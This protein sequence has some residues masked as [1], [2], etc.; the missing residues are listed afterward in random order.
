M[1]EAWQADPWSDADLSDADL[2]EEQEDFSESVV[3]RKPRQ[4]VPSTLHLSEQVKLH[5]E[6]NAE[7]RIRDSGTERQW[8][9]AMERLEALVTPVMV[10]PATLKERLS[11][12]S[13]PEDSFYWRAHTLAESWETH[14]QATHPLLPAVSPPPITAEENVAREA[15]WMLQGLDQGAFAAKI[16]TSITRLRHLTPGGLRQYLAEMC[17]LGQMVAT[18]DEFTQSCSAAGAHLTAENLISYETLQSCNTNQTIQAFA[19]AVLDVL[20]E[21]RVFLTDLEGASIGLISLATALV[22]WT[23][24]VGEHL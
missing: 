9:E 15:L 19:G 11:L 21:Y 3:P 8:L 13:V 17:K 4:A 1:A 10:H 16:E 12:F 23:P 14:F 22:E 20:A 2:E 18:M 7:I 5:A 24:K 6:L